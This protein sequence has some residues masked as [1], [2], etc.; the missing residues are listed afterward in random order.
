MDVGRM[1]VIQ[2]PTD[3]IVALWQPKRH[4]GTGVTHVHGTLSWADLFTREPDRASRFYA[5]LFQ[6]TITPEHNDA[7]GYLHIALG[8]HHVG[9]IPPAKERNPQVPPHWLAYFHVTNCDEST[10]KAKQLGATAMGP[11][12]SME[13]VGRWAVLADPQGAVFA[14]FEP[15]PRS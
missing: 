8:E 12:V 15:A 13:G 14:I 10:A 9:G 4:A 5:G 1:A 11:A 3:A 2:D 7:S 6:W